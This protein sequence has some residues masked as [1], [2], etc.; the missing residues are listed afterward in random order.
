MRS[1]SLAALAF[2]GSS[3]RAAAAD[4]QPVTTDLLAKE[5][6]GYGGLSGVVVDRA[7][8]HVFV[9]L[10]DRGVFRSTDQGKTWERLGKDAIKGRTETPGCLQLD[11]TGKT[12]RLL[13]PTVY[14]GPIARRHDR[15][16]RVAD[17]STRR[18]STSIG[19]P[20]DW[21]DP[22]LKFVLALKHESGGL[23]LR[24]RDGGKT[25]DRGRQG[26]RPGV[27]VRRRHGGRRAG[28]DRRTSRR[29]GSSARPTAGRRSSR[30]A[31]TPRVSLPRLARRRAVLA[32]RRGADQDDRQGRDVGEGERREGRPVRPG[33]RQG[34]EAPV[35]ADRRRRGR[36]HRRRGDVGEAD[37]RCRRS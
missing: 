29:A 36:E 16:G 13:L 20:A 33:V 35:R 3:A 22:D 2:L 32:R 23:L 5:K 8:G 26:L 7:T 18:R 30:S 27:G 11:P 9:N 21:T 6:P 17:R 25:F 15:Q 14:G 19:A 1:A 4:W 24:S 34:R 37:R 10:S 28:E 31:T 12:K